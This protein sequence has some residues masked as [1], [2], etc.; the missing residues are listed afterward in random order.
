V[1]VAQHENAF[2]HYAGRDFYGLH[3]AI[4]YRPFKNTNINLEYEYRIMEGIMAGNVLTEQYSITARTPTTFTTLAATGAG[5]TFIPALN[6][7][8]DTV[9]RRR[10]TGIAL[11]IEDEK[12]WQREL[13]FLGPDAQRDT[14]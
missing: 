1:I 5:R 8:Y 14:R 11:V 9:G 7:T 10:S 6:M 4:N 3:T 13:N 12:I 2:Q